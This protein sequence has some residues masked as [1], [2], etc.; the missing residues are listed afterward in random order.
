M[1]DDVTYQD[2]LELDTLLSLQKPRT[3]YPRR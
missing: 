3:A 1:T 2:Y